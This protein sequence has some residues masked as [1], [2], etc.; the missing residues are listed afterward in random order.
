MKTEL[1]SGSSAIRGEPVGELAD[2]SESNEASTNATSKVQPLT[3]PQFKNSKS[4]FFQKFNLPCSRSVYSFHLNFR[5]SCYLISVFRFHMDRNIPLDLYEKGKFTYSLQRK[6]GLQYIEF[7]IDDA[8]FYL[9]FSFGCCSV[10]R[11]VSFIPKNSNRF[12]DSAITFCVK[13]NVFK[14]IESARQ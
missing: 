1:T 14:S 12:L 5:N 7:F 2:T 11:I 4:K 3:L 10:S 13:L 9:L 8:I 6:R